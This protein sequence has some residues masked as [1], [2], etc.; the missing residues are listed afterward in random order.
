MVESTF[1]Q[2]LGAL[3]IDAEEMASGQVNL[4]EFFG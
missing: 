2:L 3:D 1:D 4:M